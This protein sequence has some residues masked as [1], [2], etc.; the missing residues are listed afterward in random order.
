MVVLAGFNH[1]LDREP[2]GSLARVRLE[3]KQSLAVANR[4]L[5]TRRSV[6][7]H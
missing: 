5:E 1:D 7:I 2:F 4:F 3:T 6:G